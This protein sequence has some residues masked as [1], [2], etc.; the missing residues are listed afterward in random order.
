MVTS[1]EMNEYGRRLH[2]TVGLPYSPVAI[3]VF[4]NDSE[5]PAE[6]IHP[7][8]D[9]NCHYGYCQVISLVKTTGKTYALAKEDHWCWKPLIAFGL[10]DMER[11]SDIYPI[12]L[13]NCGIASTD[14]ADY[15]FKNKFPMMQRNNDR[16]IVIAPLETASFVPDVVLVYCDTNTQ[17]RDLI[18]GYKRHSGK[19]VTSEFDYMDSCIWS[20]FPTHY[21]RKLHVTFPDPG[22]TG[23]GCC[24]ETEV[25]LSVPAEQLPALV[26]D[27]EEKKKH[28]SG[29]TLKENGTIMPDFP[30]PEFYNQLYKAW[31]LQTG[32][33]SWN[34]SQRG[35]KI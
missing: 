22:E 14:R 5:V 35:Y 21:E 13:Q 10:V 27:C 4:E 17:L 12:V 30:R 8:R 33:V 9:L 23:R 6:A 16:V 24:G 3:R 15:F 25:I 19:L 34:E 31:G 1:K 32:E 18:A 7:Y 2:E 29:R 20:F 26:E 11:N 28:A